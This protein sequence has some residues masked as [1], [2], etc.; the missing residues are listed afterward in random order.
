MAS[1]DHS[2]S[3]DDDMTVVLPPAPAAVVQTVNI[4]SHVPVTLDIAEPNY[5]QWRCLFDSVLG[6]FGL[7][8]HVSSPT[9][10][11]Q[12]DAE[13]VMVDHS[14]VN[15][16]YTTISKTVFDMVYKPRTTAFSVWAEIEGVFRDN[17]LHRAVY[18]EAEFRSLRQGDMTMAAYTGRLKKLADKLRDVGHPVSESSQ[19]LNLLRGLNP[20]YRYVKPVITSKSPPHTFR[21]ACSY[22]LLE[23]LNADNEVQMEAD[24]AYYAGHRSDG[25]AGQGD[26]SHK[27]PRNKKRGK[28]GGATSSNGG[29]GANAGGSSGSSG[30]GGSGAQPVSGLP[31]AAGY[32][33]W[34][35]LVQAWPM[36]FRAPGAG[37]LGPR[38]P[39]AGQQAMTAQHQLDPP[40]PAATP[41][42]WDTT[43]LMAA[44]QNTG[45]AASPPSS[46][47]WFLDTG[48]STHMSN[49]PG[50]FP[51]P[52][53]STFP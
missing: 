26:S 38:P 7:T 21:S 10:M 49:T 1:P 35:G 39:V 51:Y 43:A 53:P 33:P 29:V 50:I 27:K 9:L 18:D 44:L 45:T 24:A 47:E 3:S 15:W 42:P 36:A 37:I 23:E 13:W 40:G 12:R 34:T 17:E 2:S 19:V 48:A 32:N 41:S 14:V 28:G 30:S 22:L 11:E 4:R 25:H 20:K 16:I 6:K 52:T 8:V 31:W 46:S 5:T